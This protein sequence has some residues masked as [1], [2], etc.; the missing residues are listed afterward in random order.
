M[1]NAKTIFD[2][3]RQLLTPIYE[4]QEAQAIAFLVLE[5]TLGLKKTDVLIGK[6]I[7]ALPN[8]WPQILTDLSKNIPVQYL[9]GEADFYG[10]TFE[11]NSNVLIPRNET[12]ELVE[13]VLGLAK[14][15]PQPLHILDIGTGSGCIAI[16]LA[17]FLKNSNLTAFDISESALKTAQN[18]AIHNQVKVNFE[19]IDI[20]QVQDFPQTFDL[21]VSNPP[22]VRQSEMAEMT[23]H[24]NEH[25]PHLALF[26]PDHDPLIYY[27]AIAQFCRKNLKSKGHCFVEINEAFGQAT[28]QLFDDPHF[29][30]VQIIKDIHQKDRFVQATKV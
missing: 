30:N 15:M 16:T 9:L 3:L 8:N 26:V 17:K 4:A 7:E 18:N 12:E 19:Q 2:E 24:V 13:A 23:A 21:I 29:Y 20:L 10:L 1:L 11:V 25:E 28:A 14:T 27:K 22:Y 6:K 5:K